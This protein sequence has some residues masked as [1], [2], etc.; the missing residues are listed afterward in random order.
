MKQLS[1]TTPNFTR[2]ISGFG[3]QN[4]NQVFDGGQ[5]FIQLKQQIPK[6]SGSPPKIETVTVKDDNKTRPFK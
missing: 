6:I 5:A 2:A 4:A 3:H 1:V